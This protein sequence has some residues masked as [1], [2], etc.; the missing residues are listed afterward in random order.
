MPKVKSANT[1]SRT[2]PDHML[3][4]SLTSEDS[5]R[6]VG[7]HS[8]KRQKLFKRTS[9]FKPDFPDDLFNNSEEDVRVHSVKRQKL[10]KYSSEFP[11][12]STEED[13][14]DSVGIKKKASKRA[15]LFR[16]V[17]TFQPE[18]P[19]LL[20]D[21][22]S[23]IGTAKEAENFCTSTPF[24]KTLHIAGN[25]KIVEISPIPLP[26]RHE[27]TCSISEKGKADPQ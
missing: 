15:A 18:F 12:S 5:I 14:N 8:V 20:F 3:S 22:E 13:G 2:V 23:S 9:V 7:V 27:K 16:R 21:E 24:G 25:H 11:N 17:S 19:T 1:T 26:P 4:Q 6:D 10:L